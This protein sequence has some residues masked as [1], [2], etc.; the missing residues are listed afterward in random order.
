M[1]KRK[2]NGATV[3]SVS[4]PRLLRERMRA[5]QERRYVCWS[6]LFVVAVTRYLDKEEKKPVR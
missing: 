2:E 4:V 5:H 6:S 3:V 1:K